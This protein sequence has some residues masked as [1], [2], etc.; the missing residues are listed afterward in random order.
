M[1]TTSCEGTHLA[2]INACRVYATFLGLALIRGDTRVCVHSVLF[3]AISQGH[4]WTGV[5][6]NRTSHG[7]AI[8]IRCGSACG[9]ARLQSVVLCE[10]MLSGPP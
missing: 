5:R 9:A 10:H 1:A 3:G 8:E 2:I 6:F 4:T 7:Q